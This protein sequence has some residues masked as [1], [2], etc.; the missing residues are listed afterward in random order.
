MLGC[1]S[2]RRITIVNR[3]LTSRS[4]AAVVSP[5]NF[6]ISS[7]S[8]RKPRASSLRTQGSHSKSL[9]PGAGTLQHS[10][11]FLVFFVFFAP[12]SLFFMSHLFIFLCSLLSL[13]PFLLV[14]Q[15]LTHNQDQVI[16]A[17]R[18]HTPIK[19]VCGYAQASVCSKVCLVAVPSSYGYY[20]LS[21]LL[22]LGHSARYKMALLL[23]WML[24]GCREVWMRLSMKASSPRP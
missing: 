8:R 6:N 12:H 24:S 11:L 2:S 23:S 19:S 14:S 5:S 16:T 20:S 9:R 15:S 22:R 4:S 7:C 13:C 21:L 18:L 3:D 1:I 10:P 17:R